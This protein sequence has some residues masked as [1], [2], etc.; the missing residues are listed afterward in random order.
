VK[1]GE[2]PRSRVGPAR[3]R[4][5]AAARDVLPGLPSALAHTPRR[6]RRFSHEL[7]RHDRG[8]PSDRAD[9]R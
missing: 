8:D 9:E 7:E 6:A 4:K 2:E 1:L 5:Y 3:D